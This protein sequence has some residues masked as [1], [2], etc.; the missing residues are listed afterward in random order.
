MECILLS[1]TRRDEEDNDTDRVDHYGL[2]SRV[3]PPIN[4]LQ[5]FE[6]MT[7]MIRDISFKTVK[8]DFQNTLNRDAARIKL[9]QSVLVRADK[10]R[11]L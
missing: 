2:Y 1:K 4:E 3:S 11:N 5:A 6:N 8:E 7:K 10:T 9:S